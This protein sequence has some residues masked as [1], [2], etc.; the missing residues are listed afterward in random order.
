MK[1][2]KHRYQGENG[3]KACWYWCKID[4]HECD[5][6]CAEHTRR[7][8]IGKKQERLNELLNT[9]KLIE[10]MIKECQEDIKDLES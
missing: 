2:C 5:G 6:K 9:K 8:E 7:Y 10:K 1:K 4:E 3:F